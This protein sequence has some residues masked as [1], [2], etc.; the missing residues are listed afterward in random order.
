LNRVCRELKIDEIWDIGRKTDFDP[1]TVINLPVTLCGE[2]S[3][4][5]V[6]EILLDSVAGMID[7][8]A[9]MLAKS[10]VF[11]AFCAH[12]MLPLVAGYGRPKTADGLHA[13]AHYHLI[14]AAGE[15]DHLSAQRIANTALDWYQ[16][17]NLAIQ[18][19][20]LA[21]HLERVTPE[22]RELFVHA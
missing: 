13:G 1:A 19:Q 17:H 11:A 2:M 14:D 18:T 10:T 6:S 4:E 16:T 8:P 9:E 3:S 21:A 20:R 5:K 22:A 12:R 7:Y 15:V